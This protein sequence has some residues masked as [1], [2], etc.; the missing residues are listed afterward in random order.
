MQMKRFH[1]FFFLMAGVVIC[2][3]QNNPAGLESRHQR[4]SMQNGGSGRDYPG[5]IAG[6]SIVIPAF[7]AKV[8]TVGGNGADVQGY[9]SQ[10]IQTAVNAL[11]VEGGG[12]VKILPGEYAISA[13][14]RLFDS[15]RLSG[16]GEQTILKKSKGVRTKF[17]T[18][19][20][21]GELQLTVADTTG[22]AP[23]MGVQ[24]YDSDHNSAWDVTTAVI[25]AIRDHVVYIDN[26]LIRDY[27]AEKGGTLSNACSVISAVEASHVAITDLVVDGNRESNDPLNGCRGGG[28]YLH[29]VRDV[30]I[31]NVHV[32]NF[33]SDGISWQIT[34]NVT[35]RNCEVTG[36]AN[37]GL[38]PGAGTLYTRIEENYCH[39]N[40]IYGLFVCWR[41]RHGVVRGN[42]FTKN[43]HFGIDTGHMDTDMLFEANQIS[44]NGHAGVHFRPEIS[45]NAP[46]RTIFRNNVVENNGGKNEGYGF[47][48]DSPAEDVVLDGNTIQNTAGT[49]Q[50]AAVFIGKNGRAVRLANNHVNGHPQTE[51][52][53][54]QK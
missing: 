28:I 12:T 5:D 6:H 48:I 51:T 8:I 52:M 15:V 34:E 14:I 1:L 26:Y 27:V 29:K 23:G 22:F 46:H 31:E 39:D 43:G 35:V 42:R 16:S 4:D 10:A 7:P 17:V 54:H 30:T 13:P 45:A 25:T 21:Y 11:R 36:C 24:I 20:G 41:V 18:D 50:K 37:A 49:M 40:D 44:E 9:T 47:F 3:A 2:S 33:D 19:A 32:R 53:I 38:H